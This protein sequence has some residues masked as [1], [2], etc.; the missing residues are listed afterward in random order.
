MTELASKYSGE[1]IS[2][3]RS[4]DDLTKILKNLGGLKKYDDKVPKD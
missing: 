4:Y 1:E 2:F 3:D